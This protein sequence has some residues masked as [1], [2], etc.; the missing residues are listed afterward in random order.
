[1]PLEVRSRHKEQDALH[2]DQQDVIKLNAL[3]SL[4][5]R[6]ERLAF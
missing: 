1:L 6:E 2:A 4:A 3:F 5:W